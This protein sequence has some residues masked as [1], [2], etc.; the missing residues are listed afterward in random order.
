MFT[1]TLKITALLALASNLCAETLADGTPIR[2][3]LN[4]TLHSGRNK[5]GQGVSLSVVED[6]IIGGKTVIAAGARASGRVLM[7]DGKRSMDGLASW[8]SRQRR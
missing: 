2:L 3:R 8:T 7:A 5:V 6:V 1:Q 4:E